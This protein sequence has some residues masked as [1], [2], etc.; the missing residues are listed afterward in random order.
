M[1][2]RETSSLQLPPITDSRKPQRVHLDLFLRQ[3]STSTSA[4]LLPKL[5]PPG[6]LTLGQLLP[7]PLAPN[8]NPLVVAS[9]CPGPHDYFET[10]PSFFEAAVPLNKKGLLPFG[11][12]N[13]KGLRI[14][15]GNLEFLHVR[16]DE[17]TYRTLKDSDRMF[18]EVCRDANARTFMEQMALYKKTFYFVVGLQELKEAT[19]TRALLSEEGD[20]QHSNCMPLDANSTLPMYA[21]FREVPRNG[22]AVSESTKIGGV[23]GIEV[24]RVKCRLRKMAEPLLEEEVSWKYTYQ[25]VKGSRSAEEAEVCVGLDTFVS[26]D[27]LGD[28]LEEDEDEDQGDDENEDQDEGEDEDEEGD[29]RQ[30]NRWYMI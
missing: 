13:L 4:V 3:S 6:L 20:E 9:A 7:N 23:F 22:V 19:I 18:R 24:R 1:S 28:S 30:T 21:R 17:N 27:Q 2:P 10:E 12:L 14:R 5:F 25:K 16:S 15:R 26:A 8:V 11:S 29:P